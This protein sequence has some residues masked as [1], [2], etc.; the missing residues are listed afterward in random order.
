[1]LI[2]NCPRPRPRRLRGRPP[3]RPPHHAGFCQGGS[4]HAGQGGST[5]G[6]GIGG[7]AADGGGGGGSIAADCATRSTGGGSAGGAG[8]GSTAGSGGA[9]LLVVVGVG[10]L[11]VRSEGERSQR[12][13]VILFLRRPVIGKKS[14]QV[15][16]C[17][18]HVRDKDREYDFKKFYLI[19]FSSKFTRESTYLIF[20]N[21]RVTEYYTTVL[22]NS[23]LFLQSALQFSLCMTDFY[24]CKALTRVQTVI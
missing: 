19:L 10:L 5:G 15:F 22:L 1:M 2:I 23:Y 18:L 7:S 3:P 12:M 13:Y 20:N 24:T 8:G 17:H 11:E 4:G 6:S 21:T 9:V 16:S 14:P